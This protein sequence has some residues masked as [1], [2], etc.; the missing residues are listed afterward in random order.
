MSANTL[1]CDTLGLVDETRH[2]QENPLSRTVAVAI[3]LPLLHGML[4]MEK[5]MTHLLHIANYMLFSFF[6]QA[7][8]S[9][10][11]A[12]TPLF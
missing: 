7:G 1:L 10:D 11:P 4:Q 5:N 3:P 8:L 9:H 2:W 6:S 12:F